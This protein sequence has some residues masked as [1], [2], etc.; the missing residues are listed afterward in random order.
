MHDAFLLEAT[1]TPIGKKKGAFARTRPDVLAAKLLQALAA[2][3][4]LDTD[5]VED[6][7]LGCVTQIGEQAMNIARN[8]ALMA[9]FP[10]EVPG[11]TVNRLCGSSQQAIHFAAQAIQSGAMQLVVAGGVES[12]SR[13]PLGADAAQVSGLSPWFPPDPMLSD[14]YEFLLQGPAAERIA[15]QYK[16]SRA[17]S[18]AF[19]LESHRRAA[20]AREKGYWA[21][22]ISPIEIEGALG[23]QSVS[24]DEGI[25]ADTTLEALAKLAPAF[26]PEGI[27]TAGSS[28]QISDGAAALLLGTAAKAEELGLTP[29]ARI[30]STAVVGSDPTLMLTGPAPA[31]RKALQKAGLELSDIDL[32]EVNEAFAPVVLAFARDLKLS[33]DKINVNGGAIALGHPLGSSGARLMTSLLHEVERRNARYGLCTMCIGMGQATATIIERVS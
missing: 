1:R 31:T 26:S 16:I 11:V 3:A 5:E 32:F 12:M 18:D 8:A 14:R 10:K 17:E 7:I 23:E 4:G 30:V 22:E 33:T 29:R 27:L 21:E 19:S 25:R 15:T 13:V 24:E 6:V 2:R 28:S 20:Q 9:G